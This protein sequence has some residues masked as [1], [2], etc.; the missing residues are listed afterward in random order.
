MPSIRQRLAALATFVPG[1]IAPGIIQDV[2]THKYSAAGY[3]VIGA[4]YAS[5][6]IRD[7]DRVYKIVRASSE[8]GETGRDRLARDLR[9]R[10]DALEALGSHRLE[11]VVA[12]CEDFIGSDRVVVLRQSYVEL[13]PIDIHAIGDEHRESL[14]EF[15]SKISLLPQGYLPDILGG[16]NLGIDADGQMRL[17]DT[18][19]LTKEGDPDTYAQVQGLIQLVQQQLDETADPVVV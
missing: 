13:Q 10:I 4:G 3:D 17:V 8:I 9:H 18:V 1:A 12:V 6:V 15:F 7:E 19:A 11:T 5:T 14:R 2:I 16:G